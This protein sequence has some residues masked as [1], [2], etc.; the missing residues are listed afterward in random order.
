LT[1]ADKL[2]FQETKWRRATRRWQSIKFSSR[3]F[4]QYLNAPAFKSFKQDFRTVW[5]G[6]PDHGNAIFQGV[7]EFAGHRVQKP[8]EQPWAL[9]VD[10]PAWMA[11]LH[12]FTWLADIAAVEADA[13]KL[14]AQRM[15]L[16][17]ID[18]NRQYD[19][20]IWGTDVTA[21]RLVSWLRHGH[22]LLDGLETRHQER[23][24]SSLAGQ[25]GFLKS[26]YR[27]SADGPAK[28]RAAAALLLAGLALPVED[29]FLIRARERFLTQLAE[30]GLSNGE[31][32]DRTPSAIFEFSRELI[33][34]EAN[35]KAVEPEIA[36]KLA[37]V[38]EQNMTVLQILRHSD[39][40]L[41]VFGGGKPIPGSLLDQTIEKSN[42]S[43]QLTSSAS[44]SGF[45]RLAVNRAVALIDAGLPSAKSVG[46]SFRPGVLSLEF[47]V[48]PNR[49]VVNGAHP[50]NRPDFASNS[51]FLVDGRGASDF[52]LGQSKKGRSDRIKCRRHE[53]EAD[54][55]W[56]ETV[57]GGFQDRHGVLHQR[58]F[59]LD[60]DGSSMRG[61]DVLLRANDKFKDDIPCSALFYL[62]PDVQASRVQGGGSVILR[63]PAGG[64]WQFRADGGE[65]E[66]SDSV[67]F[68]DTGESRR[69]QHILVN[70]V[71]TA[72][73]TKIRWVFHR[74]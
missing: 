29:K 23:V 5:P 31:Y 17:W 28:F 39:S 12:G 48:G 49:V 10:Q 21:N 45:Q 60:G 30:R 54:S 51:C 55:V 40:G 67:Y 14:L 4:N 9:A 33:A 13:A 70:G 41:A 50:V 69:S 11:E 56:L 52:Q 73:G 47:S 62:H 16:S 22:F 44:S 53:D 1:A 24:T 59:F 19:P 32:A 18:A 15:V 34:L 37:E 61:E 25:F 6:D 36:G 58:R 71:T 63:L 3:L 46:D 42:A 66:L 43:Y 8:N 74:L 35:L 68:A 64:G 57:H 20:L 38:I 26:V 2:A 27:A 72:A 7:F 65:I